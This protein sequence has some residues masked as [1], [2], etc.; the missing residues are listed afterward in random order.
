MGRYLILIPKLIWRIWRF[1][2]AEPPQGPLLTSPTQPTVVR[3]GPAHRGP[4]GS[5][6][7]PRD[8]SRGARSREMTFGAIWDI[9]LA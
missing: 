6:A 1:G 3:H 4:V 7:S 8:R 9:C 5:R 2:R